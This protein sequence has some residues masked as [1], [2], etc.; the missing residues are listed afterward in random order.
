[1]ETVIVMKTKWNLTALGAC[2]A[3]MG[4]LVACVMVKPDVAVIPA[5]GV[6]TTLIAALGGKLREQVEDES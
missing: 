1:M 4:V 2:I 3:A 6:V 5:I